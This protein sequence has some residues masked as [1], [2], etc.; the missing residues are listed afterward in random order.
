MLKS[1]AQLLKDVHR[2]AAE[3]ARYTATM[4]VHD[5]QNKSPYWDGYFA[6]EW[7]V[8][9]GD[10]TIPAV[11]EGAQRSPQ[12]QPRDITLAIVPSPKKS[13]NSYTY[14][15]G[16]LMKYRA[17]AMDLVPGRN[18]EGN[19]RNYVEKGWFETYSQGGEQLRVMQQAT[20]RVFRSLG[21]K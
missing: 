14:T 12:P 2:G 9:Q 11:Y 19:W 18:A 3:S 8:K 1:F 16:N 21:F 5:I 10:V 20:N 15:I 7:V 17:I 13:G 4:L 6:N